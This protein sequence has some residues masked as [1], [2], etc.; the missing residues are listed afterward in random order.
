MSIKAM[1]ADYRAEATIDDG[2]WQPSWNIT[3]T[4]AQPTILADDRGRRLGLMHWGWRRPWATRPLINATVEKLTTSSTW[5]TAVERRRCL[6]PCTGWWEW[7]HGA[8]GKVPV[9]HQPPG[10]G[11]WAF[12]ALW[13]RTDDD[14]RF[15]IIT[16]PAA[17]DITA[18]HD[19][20]PAL[21]VGD[22]C[23]TWIDPERDPVAVMPMLVPRD[24]V[25][26]RA[27]APF[28]RDADGPAL[29]A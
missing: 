16:T 24:G 3:P 27:V 18:I 13:D 9:V 5:R 26:T 7:T 28:A 29:I 6:V 2:D 15:T 10:P 12:A 25:Q 11:P 8:H 19:R 4:T 17:D 21:L 14:A 23:T 22:E 20:M 1:A